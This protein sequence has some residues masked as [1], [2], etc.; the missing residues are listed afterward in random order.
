MKVKYNFKNL[1]RI[2]TDL[3]VVTNVS[4]AFYDYDQNPLFFHTPEGDFC[5]MIQ[6]KEGMQTC[7]NSDLLLIQKCAQSRQFEQHLCHTGLCDLAMPVIKHDLIVG[8]I[9]FGRIRTPD[10]AS[11]PPK[12]FATLEA[13]Y[14]ETP[15]FSYEKLDCMK[16]LLPRILFSTAIEIDFDNYLNQ[17]TDYIDNHLNEKLNI[18]FL[19]SH[20]HI[21]KDSLYDG[22]RETF[23]CTVNEYISSQRIKKAKQLLIDTSEPI[24]RITEAVGF[25]M[26]ISLQVTSTEYAEVIIPEE[27][28]NAATESTER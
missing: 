12:R 23:Y 4:M 21:S 13:L 10:T 14:N 28:I 27:V 26:T 5:S 11:K 6:C 19:C 1:K 2:I 3:S 24:Y 7:V 18:A 25:E 8:Y 22:F 15:Y 9:I 20:F 16:D 17:I